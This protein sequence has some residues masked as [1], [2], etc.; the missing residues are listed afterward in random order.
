MPVSLAST[1]AA[2]TKGALVPIGFATGNGSSGIVNFNNIPQN[3]QDLQVVIFGKTTDASNRNGFNL[4]PNGDGTSNKSAT[5]LTGDGASVT[6][7]RYTNVIAINPTF[8]VTTLGSGIF[9]SATIHCLNYAQSSTLKT[10]L[11]RFAGDNNGS[12]QTSLAV[13]LH[14][15]TSAVTSL[16]VFTQFGNW[17]AGTTIALYGVRTIGQ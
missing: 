17:T 8:N 10:Y 14:S 16:G 13:G 9:F 6:S 11:V 2:A 5:F 7:S 1:T 12:G 4:Y 15:S 3:F